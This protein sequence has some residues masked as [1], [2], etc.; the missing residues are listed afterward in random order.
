MD[1]TYQA[2][3]PELDGARLVPVELMQCATVSNSCLHTALSRRAVLPTEHSTAA[4]SSLGCFI[5]LHKLHI[6]QAFTLLAKVRLSLHTDAVAAMQITNDLVVR[7]G[8]GAGSCQGVAG[9][10]SLGFGYALEESRKPREGSP[11]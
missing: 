3:A 6:T 4:C 5:V 8:D 1:V 10:T 2:A 7:A 9:A 11:V